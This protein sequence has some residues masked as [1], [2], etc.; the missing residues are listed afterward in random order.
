MQDMTITDVIR[1]LEAIREQQGDLRVR[2]NNECG[3]AEGV[4]EDDL[5]WHTLSTGEKVVEFDV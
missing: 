5:Y 2:A 1:K 3:T 4:R